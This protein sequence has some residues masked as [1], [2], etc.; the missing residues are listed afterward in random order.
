MSALGT[1]NWLQET[2]G[3]LGR[4]DRLRLVG[5]GVRA[6]ASARLAGKAAESV[7]FREVETLTPPD[8]PLA[9]AAKALCREASSPWL[10]GHSLRAWYWGRLLDD[11]R[12]P[13]DE[14]AVWVAFLLHDLG[15]T[16]T[17]RLK[18][19]QVHCF[20]EPGA[21]EAERLCREHGWS[22][23][24]AYL[25]AN[26]IALHLN[27]IAGAEHGR[28]AQ[29]MRTGAGADIVG[30]GV[31]R[32]PVDQ[33]EA[34]LQRHPRH[35]FKREVSQVMLRETNE[36]PCCRMA[37]LYGKLGFGRMIAGAPFNS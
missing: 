2:G 28:E 9:I 34:V 31:S 4:L 25:A 24:R 12:A 27:V 29:I 10:Y 30:Q 14:E 17:H 32:I 18:G 1:W 8:T 35:Y 5:Q 6:K 26:A 13:F 23:E 11:G 33:R 22:D 15:L 36:R 37:F 19:E 20:T 7:R 21:R 16:D 3:K